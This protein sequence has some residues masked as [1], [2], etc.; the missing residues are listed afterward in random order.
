ML[1]S[2]IPDGPSQKCKKR[3]PADLPTPDEACA[4]YHCLNE[5]V[6]APDLATVKFFFWL[7][8]RYELRQDRGETHGLF[9]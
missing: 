2:S 7:L 3:A 1:T 5:E 4:R 6:E 9:D 8:H